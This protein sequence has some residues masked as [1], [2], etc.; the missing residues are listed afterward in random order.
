[1]L[2]DD[3]NLLAWWYGGT[4]EFSVGGRYGGACTVKKH[5]EFRGKKETTVQRCVLA[6]LDRLL[7]KVTPKQ[8]EALIAAGVPED[9]LYG[10]ADDPDLAMLPGYLLYANQVGL[11][12]L[13]AI[14]PH[15]PKALRRKI[16]KAVAAT[17]LEL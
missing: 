14:L 7:L 13:A 16:T 4:D 9:P 15:L 6:P 12:Q 10:D 5:G 17:D 1:M 3:G 8:A 2:T 11:A